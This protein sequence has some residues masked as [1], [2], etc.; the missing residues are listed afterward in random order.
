VSEA[1]LQLAAKKYESYLNSST[2]TIS[3]TI[4]DFSEKK[5][6]TETG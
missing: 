3:G 5:E 2:G 6:L 4:H 1:D